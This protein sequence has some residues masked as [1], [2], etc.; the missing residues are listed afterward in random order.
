[1]FWDLYLK[2]AAD[3]PQKRGIGVGIEIVQVAI[4]HAIHWRSNCF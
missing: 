1:M 2:A 3:H 4:G